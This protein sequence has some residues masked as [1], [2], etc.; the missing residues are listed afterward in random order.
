MILPV[1]AYGC[2]I[3]RKSGETVSIDNP[4][5]K[6][7]ISNMFETMYVAEGVGLAAQQVGEDLKIFVI[8]A[9]P[10]A[11]NHPETKD[12]KKVFINAKILE[13]SGEELAYE[14]GCL[15]I[16]NIREDVVRKSKIRITYADENFVEHD[17]TYDGMI[18]RIIQHEYDHNQ[19]IFFV[20]KINSL[21]KMLL[22]NK[23]NNIMK[24][25]VDIRYKMKF[26]QMKKGR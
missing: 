13:E 18:A 9:S 4:R 7:L 6:E 12:F 2:P 15:S 26:P 21:R 16:P 22:K 25:A 17:E 5:I 19:G 3:L 11:E 10:H 8:D 20:D 23:L 24:G 14:E 1:Y